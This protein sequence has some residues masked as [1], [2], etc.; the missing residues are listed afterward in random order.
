M[1]NYVKQH[2]ATH[3]SYL[4][5]EAMPNSE[6]Q[7]HLFLAHDY[8]HDNQLDGIELIKAFIIGQGSRVH[9]D[10]ELSDKI[11]FLLNHF[12]AD[13]DGKLSFPEFRRS[14]MVISQH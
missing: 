13:R 1:E 12:D 4:N 6:K 7:H 11:D 10:E 9:S 5:F 8:D 3:F 2:M 14:A